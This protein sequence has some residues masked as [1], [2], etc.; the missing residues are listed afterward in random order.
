L[1]APTSST[2]PTKT[3]LFWV[4]LWLRRQETHNILAVSPL[5]TF[6]F[7]RTA[8]KL[9]WMCT[10]CEE[11]RANGMGRPDIAYPPLL[12]HQ[13]PSLAQISTPDKPEAAWA[14]KCSI[15]VTII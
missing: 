11:L 1:M 13:Q 5:A 12:A 3:V 6:M 14:R 15:Q 2:Q 9:F 8:T 4:S 10:K 7:F